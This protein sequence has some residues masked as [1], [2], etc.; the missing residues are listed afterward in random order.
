MPTELDGVEIGSLTH[1]EHADEFV[2]AAVEGSLAGIR[3][4]PYDEVE[5]GAVDRSGGRQQLANVPPV[6]AHEM[7]RTLTRN[8]SRSVQDGG[9]KA[10]E[11]GRRHFAA[12]H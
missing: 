4:R 10:R 2:T 1:P 5:R 3:L 6:Y 7:D 8:C 12:R 11:I 9:E